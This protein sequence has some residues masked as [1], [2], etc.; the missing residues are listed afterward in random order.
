MKKTILQIKKN[1]SFGLGFKEVNSCL[2]FVEG[3]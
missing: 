1:T 2:Q 3:R